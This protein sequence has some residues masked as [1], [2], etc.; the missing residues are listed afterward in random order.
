[1]ISMIFLLNGFGIIEQTGVANELADAGAPAWAI[2]PIVTAG[3]MLQVTAGVALAAGFY[4]RVAAVA[5]LA[6][7]VPATLVA[8]S[9]WN[10]SGTPDFVPQLI[11]FVKNLAMSGALLFN[12]G[13]AAQPVLSSS[14]RGNPGRL[15]GAL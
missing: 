3:R 10:A 13:D 1:M 8:H 5:L 2:K 15:R 6:F 11:Q 7:L 12:V 4:P 14:E 9:F